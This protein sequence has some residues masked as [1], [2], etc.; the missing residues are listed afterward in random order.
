MFAWDIYASAK[1]QR[2][3]LRIDALFSQ[4]SNRLEAR[5]QAV[6]QYPGSLG[7]LALTNPVDVADIQKIVYRQTVSGYALSYTGFGG[8]HKSSVFSDERKAH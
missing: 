7:A 5:R 1:S 2:E 8:Y 4:I 3:A 6:G